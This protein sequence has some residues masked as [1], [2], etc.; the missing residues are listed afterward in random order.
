MPQEWIQDPT[1]FHRRSVIYANS[2]VETRESLQIRGQPR[3]EY[4]RRRP[5][6]L[7]SVAYGGPDGG[8]LYDSGGALKRPARRL[9][10]SVPRSAT[11]NAASAFSPTWS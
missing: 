3:A 1:T 8:G 7:S 4:G 11:V 9:A 6:A 5:L 10:V 2:I